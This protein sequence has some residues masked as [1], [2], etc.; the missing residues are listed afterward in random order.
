MTCLVNLLLTLGWPIIGTI[1]L[2]LTVS[3]IGWLIIVSNSNRIPSRGSSKKGSHVYF[4]LQFFWVILLFD[5]NVVLMLP[6]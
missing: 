1:S 6:W 5:M 3:T 4:L 2:L